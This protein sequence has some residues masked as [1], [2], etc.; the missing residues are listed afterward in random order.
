M[1][2]MLLNQITTLKLVLGDGYAVRVSIWTLIKEAEKQSTGQ[3]YLN[4]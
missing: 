4:F 2:E 1:Q 3:L